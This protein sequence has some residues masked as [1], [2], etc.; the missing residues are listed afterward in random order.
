MHVYIHIVYAYMCIC[1]YIHFIY[2]YTQN[3]V[4]TVL[5]S[6]TVMGSHRNIFEHTTNTYTFIYI[7][8]YIDTYMYE[9]MWMYIDIY[10]YIIYIREQCYTL[11][12][13]CGSGDSIYREQPR[14]SHE[15]VATEYVEPHEY[16]ARSHILSMWSHR[17][18]KSMWLRRLHL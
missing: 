6:A 15:Y 2:P 1:I 3:T 7:D 10:S 12:W 8:T 18:D 14:I 16:V 9:Y 4:Y 17:S 13:V 11:V 5:K